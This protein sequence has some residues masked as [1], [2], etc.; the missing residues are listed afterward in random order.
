[1]KSHETI[2]SLSHAHGFPRTGCPRCFQMLEQGVDH[3]IPDPM[4]LLRVNALG[5]QVFI[6]IG[7]GGKQGVG[8]TVCEHA[9]DFL[10]HAPVSAA[11]PRLHM[12][13]LDTALRRH[14][15]TTDR[16]VH[17]PHD[18]YTAW[19]VLVTNLVKLKHD[20]GCLIRM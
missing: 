8:E 13:H 7:R 2:F 4:N 16:A 10:G 6:P 1:M 17:I 12:G 15:S 14:Q 19:V 18:D 5:N 9:V 11:K 20:S 3:D